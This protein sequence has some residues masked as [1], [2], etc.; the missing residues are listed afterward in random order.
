MPEKWNVEAHD[1]DD[2]GVIERIGMVVRVAL[3]DEVPIR[4]TD[5]PVGDQL[6]FQTENHDIAC[7]WIAI[8][9][10]DHVSHVESRRHAAARH[11][12]RSIAEQITPAEQ[13]GDEQKTQQAENP[14]A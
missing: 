10:V 1:P 6:S 3:R 13:D 7:R 11:A 2:T 4:K 9:D 8:R 14:N 12:V 5:D